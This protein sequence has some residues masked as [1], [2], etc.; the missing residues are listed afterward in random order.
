M[1]IRRLKKPIGRFFSQGTQA[2]NPAIHNQTDMP[3]DNHLYDQIG[4]LN[5]QPII[6]HHPNS[7]VNNPFYDQIDVLNEKYKGQDNILSSRI[8]PEMLYMYRLDKKLL[9]K[10][11]TFEKNCRKNLFS[12]N[13]FLKT[14]TK[15]Y[16]TVSKSIGYNEFL[17]EVMLRYMAN[18][19]EIKGERSMR[20]KDIDGRMFWDTS[21]FQNI[22]KD[23]LYMGLP[24]VEVDIGSLISILKSFQRLKYKDYEVLYGLTIKMI[25]ESRSPGKSIID[26]GPQNPFSAVELLKYYYEV[27]KKKDKVKG[28]FTLKNQIKN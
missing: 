23:L 11:K 22:R 8:F 15:E 1:L 26:Q 27:Y 28:N 4:E 14:M 17:I 24:G 9:N 7:P 25:M 12:N 13:L 16:I 10:I 21:L 20:G 18:Y 5:K 3:V 19:M 6:H 2:I